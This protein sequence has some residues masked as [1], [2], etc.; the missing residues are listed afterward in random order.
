LAQATAREAAAWRLNEHR[1]IWQAKPALALV[2]GVW[3]EALLGTIAG[4]QRVLEVGAGPG[5]LAAH[6]RGRARDRRWVASDYIALPWN[7]VAADA[8]RLPFHTASHDAVVGVDILHHLAAPHDFFAECAR[9]LR[10]QGRIVLVEPWVTPFSYVIYRYL[11]HESCRLDVDPWRPFTGGVSAKDVLDGDAAVV[12]ALVRS[13]RPERWQAFGLST[14]E[15]KRWNCFAYLATLGFR[16]SSLLWPRLTEA[17]LR[18]D[19]LTR[20]AAPLFAL[21]ALAVWTRLRDEPS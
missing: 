6:A 2:Y 8:Q 18:L 11:H 4:A 15:I 12:R 9:I 13:T 7:D 3:F 10:P 20:S 14:P 17:L 5:F 21:R 19:R 1:Q 16:R